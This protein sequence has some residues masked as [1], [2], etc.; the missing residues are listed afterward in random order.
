MCA[1]SQELKEGET[2]EAGP[3]SD[4]ALGTKAKLCGEVT[5]PPRAPGTR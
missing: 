5:V 4:A 1:V 3:S 2:E